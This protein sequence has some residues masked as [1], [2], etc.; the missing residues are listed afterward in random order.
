VPITKVAVIRRLLFTVAALLC[1]LVIGLE[2][3]HHYNYGHFVS[4]GLHVDAMNKEGNIGIPGQTKLYWAEL[5][6][7]SFLPVDLT[8]CDYTTDTLSPG[9]DYPY[10]VQRWNASLQTWQTIADMGRKDFCYPIPL[11][12]GGTHIVFKRLWPGRSVRVMDWEAA[13]AREPFQKGDLAR[14]VVFRNVDESTDWKD[15]IASKPFQ[16]EDQVERND[17]NFRIKH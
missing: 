12:R 13:G 14:F 1:A 4:Y 3:V 2:L 8:A 7:Y 16:I 6:N 10:A 5:S 15:A 9:T 11:G 17:I